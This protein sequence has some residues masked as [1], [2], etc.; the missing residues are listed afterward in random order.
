MVKSNEL[1]N[2]ADEIRQQRLG[3][4]VMLLENY[5]LTH[6]Q[7]YNN[8][9]RM[10][11]IKADYDLMADYW[12]RGY[13]D[14]ER[15]NLC[16]QLLR[17]ADVLC[18]NLQIHHS[19]RSSTFLHDVYQRARNRRNDWSVSAVQQ[20]LENFVSELALLELEP[21]HT[22]EEKKLAL[23]QGHQL[24]TNDLFDYVFTS[25]CWNARLADAFLDMLLS[26][27][28]DSNDQQLVVS[29]VTLSALHFFDYYKFR[30]LADVY[31]QAT[32]EHVRQRALVG[33]VLALDDGRQDLYPE[34]RQT[35]EQLTADERCR[36]ELCELQQQLVFCKNAE[37]DH[38]KIQSEIMP[39]LLR[40]SRYRIT[41]NGI[42]EKEE[43]PMADILHP[44]A[45][46]EAMEKMEQS[47]RRMMDMQKHGS[48]I[49]FGGFSQMKRF[50]F[51]RELGNWFV[52]FYL[53]HPAIAEATRRVRDNKFLL[54]MLREAPFCNSDKY[55]FTIAFE[56]VLQHLPD[57]MRGM[58]ERG[59]ASLNGEMAGED[60]QKPAYVRRLYLQ[61]LYRFF[62]L[63]PQRSEFNNPFD[64]KPFLAQDLFRLTPMDGARGSVA[65]FFLRRRM[66][67]EACDVTGMPLLSTWRYVVEQKPETE[68]PV[69]GYARALFAEKRY[70]EALEAYD[71]LLTMAPEKKNYLLNKAVCQLNTGRYQE[72]L[73]LLYQIDYTHPDD[74]N[75]GRVLAWALLCNGKYEQA[76]NRYNQL[77]SAPEIVA[78]DLLN[79]G[80]CLW[81]S[82]DIISAVG[83]F[84]QYV[85]QTNVSA[86]EMEQEMMGTEHALIAAHGIT[87]N[88]ILLMLDTL[89]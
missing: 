32:D 42:E 3:K 14:P 20:D 2:I 45:S 86:D 63:H 75:V 67:D 11:N 29:A 15:D 88:E 4:A 84:R 80:Y 69:L 56:Q 46:E 24:L 28:I 61:D 17:R 85:G 58:M 33:W 72:A 73:A 70:D 49:Y 89:R 77:L 22:R 6:Q 76:A 79:Y 19:I 9:E 66:T 25:R 53:D 27:T 8:V 31:R 21:P 47:F 51:F 12:R 16:L 13:Q 23:H 59:E 82:G 48:D 36:Q 35:I 41:R 60:R 68:W 54:T 71:R 65:A 37:S 40:N 52:P 57:E 81:F 39:E 5:L 26:P 83:M 64:R 18:T 10:K 34:M 7:H 55:S 78:D 30:L 62:R 44:E 50:P 74:D 1:T 87:D 38:E 43:D